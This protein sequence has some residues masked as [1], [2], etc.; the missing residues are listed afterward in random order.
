MP[1]GFFLSSESTQTLKQ[2]RSMEEGGRRA[3]GA[4]HYQ[5]WCSA[6]LRDR[7]AAA[8][9]RGVGHVRLRGRREA[10]AARYQRWC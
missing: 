3:K 8:L 7:L 10:G 4:A 9:E 2:L 6:D 1:S 5:R